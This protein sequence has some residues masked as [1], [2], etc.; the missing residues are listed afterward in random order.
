M[1]KVNIKYIIAVSLRKDLFLISLIS[2]ILPTI[3]SSETQAQKLL[4]DSINFSLQSK[5]ISSIEYQENDP[6]PVKTM[7]NEGALRVDFLSGNKR[8][9]FTRIIMAPPAVEELCWMSNSDGS[10][11]ENTGFRVQYPTDWSWFAVVYAMGIK[12]RFDSGEY[13]LSHGSYMKV[14]CYKIIAKYPISSEYIG[15]APPRH[16]L[17]NTISKYY[18]EDSAFKERGLSEKEFTNNKDI[19]TNS[20]FA[21]IEVLIDKSPGR[22]FIYEYKAY[23][24]SGTL[25]DARNWGKI[26]FVSSLDPKLFEF[27][28][29]TKAKIIESRREY[30]NNSMKT[31]G[32]DAIPPPSKTSKMIAETKNILERNMGDTLK[33]GGHIALFVAIGTVLAIIIMKTKIKRK[34]QKSR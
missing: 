12:Q 28:E 22:P 3:Y 10:V 24:P 14:P 26:K 2:F 5:F 33:W 20:Y 1:K 9:P 29:N 18:Q 34:K 27:P 25:I 13:E 8:R 32:P 21:T 23:N 15:A 31:Y 4:K 7:V 11:I 16:F 19:L 17:V 30:A 6:N